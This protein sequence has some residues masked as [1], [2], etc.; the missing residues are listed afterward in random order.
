MQ[1][2]L[3]VLSLWIPILFCHPCLSVQ[4]RNVTIDDDHESHDVLQ[5]LPSHSWTQ[6]ANCDACPT[7]HYIDLGKALHNTWHVGNFTVGQSNEPAIVLTFTGT[8]VYVY[9]ILVNKPYPGQ[10]GLTTFTNISFYLDGEY[11]ATYVH[12]PEDFTNTVYNV[13]VYSTTAL[14]NNTHTLRIGV[15]GPSSSLVLFDYATYTVVEPDE[16]PKLSTS[17]PSPARKAVAFTVVLVIASLCLA[18][19]SAVVGVMLY[20]RRQSMSSR[21]ILEDASDT[22]RIPLDSGTLSLSRRPRP[23]SRTGSRNSASSATSDTTSSDTPGT[24]DWN[25]R[26]FAT[27]RGDRA[28]CLPS[29]LPPPS[30]SVDVPGPAVTISDATTERQNH[31]TEVERELHIQEERLRRLQ[32]GRSADRGRLRVVGGSLGGSDMSGS[33]G[34]VSGREEKIALLRVEVDALRAQVEFERRLLLEVAPRRPHRR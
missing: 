30:H 6:G 12:F 33:Q 24:L 2:L 8:A 22:P 32:Q 11:A 4:Y 10:E 20:R 1:A 7:S 18:G 3:S 16:S 15:Y 13:L 23:P 5:Y 25:V 31:I 19:A 29:T 9:N 26:Q 17:S 14:P 34:F 21:A 28:L 27:S